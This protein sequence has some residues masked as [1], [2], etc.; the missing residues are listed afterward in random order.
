MQMPLPSIVETEDQRLSWLAVHN[1]VRPSF[2]RSPR[3]DDDALGWVPAEQRRRWL[4]ELDGTP[5]AAASIEREIFMPSSTL[6]EAELLVLPTHRRRGLGS[7]LYDS[8]SRFAH[9]LGFDGL[10]GVVMEDDADSVAYVERR[11][12][13]RGER[14][15]DVSLRLAEVPPVD[16]RPLPGVVVTTLAERPELL[17]ACYDVLV[18]TIADAP[19]DEPVA[20]PPFEQWRAAT[21]GSAGFRPEAMFVAVESADPERA[22]GVAELTLSEARPHTGYHEYTAVRRES[23][24]RGIARLLK[25]HTIQYARQIGLEQLS[26]ENDERNAPMRHINISLGYR[27]DPA[28]IVY[29]G[30]LAPA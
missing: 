5:V 24:G 14:H 4:I 11:G 7:Q 18:A 21:T 15:V 9:A 3:D 2:A 8:M 22:L 25:M 20:A 27:P 28:R 19:S 26:T 17:A 23:R 16:P 29:R 6:A 30:P 12:F 1:A 10:R 13:T